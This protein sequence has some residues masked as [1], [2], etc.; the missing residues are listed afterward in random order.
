MKLSFCKRPRPTIPPQQVQPLQHAAPA[1]CACSMFTSTIDTSAEKMRP[2]VQSNVTWVLQLVEYSSDFS[3]SCSKQWWPNPPTTKVYKFD[4]I[5]FAAT[6]LPKSEL[7][8]QKQ[9]WLPPFLSL[10]GI[11]GQVTIPWLKRL[12][13]APA[14]ESIDQRDLTQRVLTNT[15]SPSPKHVTCMDIELYNIQCSV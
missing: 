5:Y 14:S 11:I 4:F 12:T 8:F 7:W 2:W 10:V 15:S 13:D 3:R 9:R 1:C 6:V